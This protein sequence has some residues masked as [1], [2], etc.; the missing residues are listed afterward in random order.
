VD[1]I[2]DR[3]DEPLLYPTGSWGPDD[4]TR[5]ALYGRWHPLEMVDA[6]T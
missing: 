6:S 1:P 5:S 2:L 4:A 3:D